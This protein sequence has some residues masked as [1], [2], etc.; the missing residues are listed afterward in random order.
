MTISL[1]SIIFF[2]ATG[3]IIT[4]VSYSENGKPAVVERKMT[5]YST[6]PNDLKTKSGKTL[7]KKGSKGRG[8]MFSVTTVEK[9]KD[10]DKSSSKQSTATPTTTRLIR[11]GSVKE[12]K[13]KFVTK[14]SSRSATSTKSSVENGRESTT[15]TKTF[16]SSKQSKTL[17]N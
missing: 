16:E 12:L 9:F 4:E 11:R 14:S 5:Q 3:S 1:F 2:V 15:V 17:A 7:E 10:D 6:D 8:E 13:E